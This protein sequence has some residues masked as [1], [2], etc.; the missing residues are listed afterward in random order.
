MVMQGRKWEARAQ[1]LCFFRGE[2][3]ERG[4]NAECQVIIFSIFVSA[5]TYFF[6]RETQ[7]LWYQIFTAHQ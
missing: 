4:V 2:G 7:T 5:F 3:R 1:L 6:A